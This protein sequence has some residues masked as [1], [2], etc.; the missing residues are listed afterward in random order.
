LMGFRL[1]GSPPCVYITFFNLSRPA[2]ATATAAAA[3]TTDTA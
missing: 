1:S 3:T 2:T